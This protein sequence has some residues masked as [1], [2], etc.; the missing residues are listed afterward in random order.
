MAVRNESVFAAKILRWSACLYLASS[1]V[2]I[3]DLPAFAQEWPAK[4]VKIIVPYPAGGGIDT[5]GRELAQALQQSSGQTVYV[6]NRPGAATA[7]GTIQVAR[8]DPDGNTIL[9]TSDSTFSINPYVFSKLS[10]NPEKDFAPVGRVITMNFVLTAH[11]SI[12]ADSLAAIIS[13]ARKDPKKYSYASFG[14]GS[15][16]QLIMETLKADAKVSL[17]HVPFK[18]GPESIQAAISGTV[19]FALSNI[20]SAKG[21]IETGKLKPIAIGGTKRSPFLPNVPT[22]AELGYPNVGAYTWYGLFVSASV[23][24]DVVMQIHRQIEKIVSDPNFKARQIERGYEVE[25]DT[26][27]SFAA[28]LKTEGESRRAVVQAAG[29]KI[30]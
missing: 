21:H 27:E 8:A 19:D 24:R 22:F 18:G 10:Y 5:L 14:A 16:P 13:E 25:N 4:A 29:I 3:C 17:L 6:E 1:I 15:Q 28:Y 30:D 7:V 9:L 23:P 11:G 12:H 2:F 26:P 20:V